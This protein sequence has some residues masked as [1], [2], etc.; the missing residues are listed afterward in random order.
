MG[1]IIRT[2]GLVGTVR[3]AERILGTQGSKIYHDISV[4]L[5]ASDPLVRARKQILSISG[6][7]TMWLRNTAE[8]NIP[9][10]SA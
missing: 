7:I 6:K 8:K 9:Y 10:I 3:E 5:W 4:G 1:I 2:M